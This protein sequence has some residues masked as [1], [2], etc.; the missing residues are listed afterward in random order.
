VVLFIKNGMASVERN[1]FEEEFY[2]HHPEHHHKRPQRG[3]QG[4]PRL[5]FDI[6]RINLYELL[7]FNNSPNVVIVPD[8]GRHGCRHN[9]G[10]FG[11]LC[12][13]CRDR[14]YKWIPENR[15]GR[16]PFDPEEGE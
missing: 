1:R 14:L 15:P 3:F 13:R 5:T 16:P 11:E 7:R 12:D 4:H 10:A 9:N 2:H 6:Q 8:F